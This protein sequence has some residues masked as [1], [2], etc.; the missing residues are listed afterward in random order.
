MKSDYVI[1]GGAASQSWRAIMG[2]HGFGVQVTG[3]IPEDNPHFR[4]CQLGITYLYKK[5]EKF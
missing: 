4:R 1:A 3:S 2:D 5:K